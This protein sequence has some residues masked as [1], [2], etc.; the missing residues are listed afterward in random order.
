MSLRVACEDGLFNID[1]IIW[2]IDEI[3]ARI[4]K[5]CSARP[6]MSDKPLSAICLSAH[7][8]TESLKTGVVLMRC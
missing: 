7:F 8:P 1:R 4:S 5:C 3:T 6:V 2:F